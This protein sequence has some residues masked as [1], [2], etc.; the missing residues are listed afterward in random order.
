MII[1]APRIDQKHARC[2][3]S[4]TPESSENKEEPFHK[5]DVES[6]GLMRQGL[7]LR[8]SVSTSVP[9]R[10]DSENSVASEIEIKSQYGNR[11]LSRNEATSNSRN[12]Q[13]NGARC[14]EKEAIVDMEKEE[15]IVRIMPVCSK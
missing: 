1:V 6:R 15:R 3:E 10:K 11:T 5:T 4:T 8:E 12:D 14:P 9:Q 7:E 2:S 13:I